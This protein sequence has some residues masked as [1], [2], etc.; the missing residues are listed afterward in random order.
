VFEGLNIMKPYRSNSEIKREAIK[1]WNGFDAKHFYSREDKWSKYKDMYLMEKDQE[2]SWNHNYVTTYTLEDLDERFNARIKG[3]QKGD[4]Q[5]KLIKEKAR[6]TAKRNAILNFIK[7]SEWYKNYDEIEIP[8]EWLKDRKEEEAMEE[9]KAK[10]SNLSPTERR[11][12]EKRM[13][14]YTLRY[15]DKKDDSFT[16]DKIEPKTIDLMNSKYRTY[17]CTKEDEGKMKQAAL[18]LK[19]IMPKH[20]EVYPNTDRSS[21]D[22]DY[23]YPVYWYDNPP[24]SMMKWNS[25]QYQDWAK[26]VQGWDTPQFIRVSQNKVKFITKNPNVK[27]IDDFFLQLTPNNGYTMDE[28]LIKYYTAYKL[29]KIKDFK[30]MQGL[31]CIHDQLQKDYCE[32]LDLRQD[33]YSEFNYRRVRDVATSITKHMDKLYEFQK[34]CNE[35]DDAEIIQEKSKEL[36]VLSDISEARAVD[37]DILAKYDNIV[38]FAEE[39]KPM[40]D[41]LEVLMDRECNMSPELEKELR[42]YLRAKSRETWNN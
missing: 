30:F 21:W 29:D 32:L 42:I 28:S 22:K 37:L 20:N 34:L 7:Q 14:A 31:G 40:L 23:K 5:Q 4:A 15:D 19:E 36:F 27:H 10:F 8:E 33:N 11:E 3:T 39:I 12:I 17:Y 35:C 13:V 6:V 1:D 24:V 41:E 9:E 18:L 16:M 25:D 26:P 2:N 38:E